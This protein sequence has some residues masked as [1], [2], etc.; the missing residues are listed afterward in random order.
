MDMLDSARLAVGYLEGIDKT[1]FVTDVRTQDAVV[2]RL[3]MI[4]EASRRLS[5]QSRAS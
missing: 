2:R 5:D 3:E 1:S 4:G